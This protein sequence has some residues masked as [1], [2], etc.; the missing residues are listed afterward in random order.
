M[1][2][3]DEAGTGVFADCGSDLAGEAGSWYYGSVWVTV[4]MSG[5]DSASDAVGGS[6]GVDESVDCVSY[7]EYCVL[8][9]AGTD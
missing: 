5:S 8:V 3:D 7:A 9:G 1:C 4:V 6:V 2:D